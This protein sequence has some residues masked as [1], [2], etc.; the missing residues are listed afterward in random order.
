MGIAS[1]FLAV[2][3]VV[4]AIV[5]VSAWLPPGAA[6]SALAPRP[7]PAYPPV[8]AAT[9]S[10]S[11]VHC[12]RAADMLRKFAAAYQSTFPGSTPG[13]ADAVRRMQAHRAGA[14]ASMYALRMRLPN[15]LHAH[16]AL[17]RH[18]QRIERSTLMHVDDACAR[19]NLGRAHTRPIDDHYY[20]HWYRA[21]NDTDV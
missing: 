18:I 15:D 8:D 7:Q 5:A 3:L 21:S 9:C 12:A 14:L 6:A 1:E 20:G 19:C 4:V 11:P 10:A 16:D 2:A 13:C 17:T